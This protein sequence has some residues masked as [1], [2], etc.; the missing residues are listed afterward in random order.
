MSKYNTE[1]GEP[2]KLHVGNG[3][4]YIESFT[5]YYADG[6]DGRLIHVDASSPFDIVVEVFSDKGNLER[7]DTYNQ[8][9][10]REHSVFYHENGLEKFEL[11]FY[12]DGQ[13]ANERI[14]YKYEFS[15]ETGEVLHVFE[16]DKFYSADKEIQTIDYFKDGEA[17]GHKDISMEAKFNLFV[18]G[19]EFKQL[20][21]GGMQCRYF[22]D[23][24]YHTVEKDNLGREVY[25]CYDDKYERYETRYDYDSGITTHT[26]SG[27]TS[28][29]EYLYKIEHPDRETWSKTEYDTFLSDG[30]VRSP[31]DTNA[32]R[33]STAK[34]VVL[35]VRHKTD[36]R[37]DTKVG[38]TVCV[39]EDGTYSSFASKEERFRE[40]GSVETIKYIDIDR[41]VKIEYYD[42]DG[43]LEKVE[44]GQL[45]DFEERFGELDY[46]FD[47]MEVAEIYATA[48]YDEGGNIVDIDIHSEDFENSF[49][50]TDRIEAIKE[51]LDGETDTDA[52]EDSPDK[53]K[54]KEIPI[55]VETEKDKIES[56]LEDQDGR[57]DL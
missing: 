57:K 40:D 56:Y 36:D 28:S 8:D 1:Q 6:R 53:G 30:V 51:V 31:F 12:E 52:D 20:P 29:D 11:F 45:E 5:D 26:I 43:K 27:C 7:V 44:Y 24:G 33:D 14:D 48:E 38:F 22:E 21:D 35:E 25:S 32:W 54:D 49:F 17:T 3:L 4:H 2:F 16:A 42:T 10:I 13:T 18:D 46:V 15:S 37:I 34:E 19:A 9:G 47:R 55:D 39:H 41:G 23:M 50:D